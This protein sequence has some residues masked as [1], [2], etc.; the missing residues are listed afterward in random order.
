MWRGISLKCK[1]AIYIAICVSVFFIGV[2]GFWFY[3]C[4]AN[5]AY[6]RSWIRFDCIVVAM[7]V[8]FS[9]PGNYSATINSKP[10]F[11]ENAYLELDLPKR[12]LSET[13]PKVLV[14]GLKGTFEIVDNEGKHLFGGSIPEDPNDLKS[15]NSKN[16]IRL[17]KIGSF[18]EYVH[19]QMN[20]TITKGA[21]R[22]KGIPHR[23]VVFSRYPSSRSDE[24]FCM[25]F[26]LANLGLAIIILSVV[27]VLSVRKKK[28][29]VNNQ[30]KVEVAEK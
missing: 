30:E 28:Q 6:F 1:I 2:A 14:E 3:F 10:R 29:S 12:A 25:L 4:L 15:Y 7:R 20:I 21:K 17:R 19:W 11:L 26:G 24:F 5:R 23:F 18:Y 22:L 9:T 16:F 27:T 13:D 8:D